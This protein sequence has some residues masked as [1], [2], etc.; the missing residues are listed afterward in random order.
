[1]G[2]AD[3][4]NGGGGRQKKVWVASNQKIDKK[5]RESPQVATIYA[6]AKG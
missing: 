2:K 6:S 5:K 1:V 4:A 3:R